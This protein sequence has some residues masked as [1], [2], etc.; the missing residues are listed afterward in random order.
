MSPPPVQY[1]ASLMQNPPTVAP[2]SLLPEVYRL[3]HQC[4]QDVEDAA[5]L[6]TTAYV[7]NWLPSTHG[8]QI[9]HSHKKT[10]R[11]KGWV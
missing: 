6:P 8:H 10:Q 2:E 1:D 9:C 11:F 7:V 5:W 3:L 4:M